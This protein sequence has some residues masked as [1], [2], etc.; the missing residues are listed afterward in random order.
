MT[1]TRTTPTV[2][3]RTRLAR[4]VVLL[5]AAALYA[6]LVDDVL[7]F[8]WTPFL[9]GLAY[10]GAAVA[11]GPRGGLWPTATVLLG[12]GLGVL[13]V[14]ETD[15]EVQRAAAEVTGVGLGVLAAAALAARG[16]SVDLL[17]VG[18]TIVL[19]GTIFLLQGHV[20]AVTEPWPYAV[21]LAAVGL[22]NLA[23]SGRSS[24]AR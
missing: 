12:W 10:L 3:P 8:T 20:D 17:G 1:P 13:V 4:G 9:L 22:A 5:V 2:P 14:F 23:R 16:F 18:A 15:L 24:R 11:G 6:L 7:A 21:L 19:A